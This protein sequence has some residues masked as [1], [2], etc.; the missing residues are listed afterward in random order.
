MHFGKSFLLFCEPLFAVNDLLL[1]AGKLFGVL[2]HY[3]PIVFGFGL[4]GVDLGVK[5]MDV[6]YKFE[7]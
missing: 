4:I 5:P 1:K 2:L 3:K 6:G 7:C